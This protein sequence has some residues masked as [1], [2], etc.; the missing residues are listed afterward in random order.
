[1]TSTALVNGRVLTEQ[2]LVADHAV[3]VS[4]GR[5]LAIVKSDRASDAGRVHDLRGRLL[6]PGFIDCQVNGGGGALFNDDPSVATLRRIGRAHRAFG[7]T[8]FLPTLISDTPD[9]MRAAIDAVR[10]A[11][12]AGEPGILGIHLE[13]PLLSPARPGVHDPAKFREPDAELLDL[14][15]SLKVGRTVLTLAPERVP[16]AVIRE[17]ARRGVI[18]CVGHTTADYAT[19]RAAFDAG[20]RGVT[21][22][23]NAMS[24]LQ[25]REPGVVGAALE[26]DRAWCGVVVDGHHVH[27][28]SLRVAVA[29][30][31]AGKIFLVTD[32]MPPVGAAD[33]TFHLGSERV[34]CENG[35]CVTEAGVL[36]GSCLDMARAVRNAVTMLG[37][38]VEEAAR[39][40][41]TYPATFL[42]LHGDRGRIAA[43]SC[44][45]FVALNDD[46]SVHEVWC[47]GALV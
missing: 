11:I 40:A 45:D 8:G 43:G 34:R 13:G 16:P 22:L 17:L 30:K 37:L 36:A 41:S 19:T 3:L 9:V 25:S 26:D 2:G 18:L 28:A 31:P 32:A 39:M 44:A 29:A 35:R 24:A 12:E 10:K 46:L 5:V 42:G 1:M 47:S 14:V 21:H 15:S 23:F 7:T 4:G 33:S 38:P 20:I 6:V 27:P